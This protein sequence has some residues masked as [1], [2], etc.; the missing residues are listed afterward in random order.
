MMV[1]ALH[2]FSEY[3]EVGDAPAVGIFWSYF[4]IIWCTVSLPETEPESEL[5]GGRVQGSGSRN[6]ST[7]SASPPRTCTIVSA[8]SFKFSSL[9]TSALR[10][11]G[12]S[13]R[14]SNKL[15]MRTSTLRPSE[16]RRHP[17]PDARFF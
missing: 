15:T 5:T 12:G 7:T 1:A 11:A 16:V 17:S 4:V 9:S 10:A 13:P 2:T 8:S 3:H 6:A 14:R